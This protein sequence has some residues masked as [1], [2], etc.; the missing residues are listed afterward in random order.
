MRK[1]DIG[2]KVE[3]IRYFIC[4][5]EK[6]SCVWMGLPRYNTTVFPDALENANALMKKEPEKKFRIIEYKNKKTKVIW[7]S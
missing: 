6:S 7:N 5:Y 4:K 2:V 3:V 1:E